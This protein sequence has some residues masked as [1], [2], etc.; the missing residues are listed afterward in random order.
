LKT[1]IEESP[2]RKRNLFRTFIGFVVSGIILELADRHGKMFFRVYL[3]KRTLVLQ[4]NEKSSDRDIR[5][6]V[7]IDIEIESRNQRETHEKFF[8]YIL[9]SINAGI[10]TAYRFNWNF[11]LFL[12]MKVRYGQHD[13]SAIWGGRGATWV[14]VHG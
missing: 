13:G 12:K 4:Q 3:K 6:E 10:S 9:Q 5:V 14:W 11:R 7:Q 8:C 2:E 1:F